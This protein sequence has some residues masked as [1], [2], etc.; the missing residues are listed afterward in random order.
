MM[1]RRSKDWNEGLAKDLRNR[2]FAQ[3]FFVALL[4]EGFTLQEALAK[5][6]RTYGVQEF[7]KKAKMPA[8]NVSRAIRP[9][10]NPSQRVLGD[11][12]EPLG[13]RLTAGPK[14][15]PQRAA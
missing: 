12:L 8:S 15:R 9:S 4:D 7:A 6:I 13:L 14:L 2:E 3:A 11:L 1:A 5:T 10:H